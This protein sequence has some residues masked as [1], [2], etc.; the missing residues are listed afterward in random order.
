MKKQKLKCDAKS[1][2]NKVY[3]CLCKKHLDLFAELIFIGK[4]INSASKILERADKK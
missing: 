3:F 4:Y 2:K 1:C